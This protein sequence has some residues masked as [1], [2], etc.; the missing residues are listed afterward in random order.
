[1]RGG[2]AADPPGPQGAREL[3]SL[4]AA[5]AAGEDFYDA[6][7][8]L[9]VCVDYAATPAGAGSV[10]IAGRAVD[11]FVLAVVP[12]AEALRAV[13]PAEEGGLGYGSLG[14]WWALE[15]V[16]MLDLRRGCSQLYPADAHLSRVAHMVATGSFSD[17]SAMSVAPACRDVLEAD[18]AEAVLGRETAR[19]ARLPGSVSKPSG[20]S[21]A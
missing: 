7:Q 13:T 20:R 11:G 15:P 8:G 3:V 9:F 16:G 19:E 12:A 2:R 21:R 6:C 10:E 5:L 4:G 17:A 1:M 18:A 14:Q